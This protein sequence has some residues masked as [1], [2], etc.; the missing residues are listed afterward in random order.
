MQYKL[1][2]AN[3]IL[4]KGGNMAFDMIPEEDDSGEKTGFFKVIEGSS[5]S[6]SREEKNKTSQ[7]RIGRHLQKGRQKQRYRRQ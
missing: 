3:L 2:K 4:D 1:L 6:T 5:N 7:T